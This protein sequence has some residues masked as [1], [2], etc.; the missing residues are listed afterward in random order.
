MSAHTELAQ[1][2]SP[3]LTFRKKH[4]GQAPPAGPLHIHRLLVLLLINVESQGVH[5]QPQ[6]CSFLVLDVKVVNS[7]H[8]QVLGDLQVLHHGVFP[9]RES[10]EDDGKLF[11]QG[12]PYRLTGVKIMCK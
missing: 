11:F 8:L 6:I 9:A 2:V 10:T 5:S 1:P 4:R 7:V 12:V 3:C